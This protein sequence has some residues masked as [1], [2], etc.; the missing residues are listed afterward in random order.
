ME[1]ADGANPERL[2]KAAE[3]T[4]YR[5]LAARGLYLSGDRP[6]LRFATKE[7]VR[8]MQNPTLGDLA[9]LKRL[10]RFLVT[11]PRLVTA[12]RY[13]GEF[14]APRAYPGM[15]EVKERPPALYAS[16]DSN[17]ADCQET[18][19]ST[20]GEPWCMAT[21]S[22]ALGAGRRRSRR[23]ARARRSSTPC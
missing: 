13:Q 20:S 17:W 22:S 11:H 5:G 2:D 21:T 8:F 1:G 9:S 19:K 7:V 18:R 16:V 23:S 12:Y 3:V 6:E 4:A 15:P 10:A 14:V